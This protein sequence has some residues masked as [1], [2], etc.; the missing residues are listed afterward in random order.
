VWKRLLAVSA[1]DCWSIITREGQGAACFVSGGQYEDAAR[2]PRGHIFI[3]KVIIFLWQAKKSRAADTPQNHVYDQGW[4]FTRK[5]SP[6]RESGAYAASPDYAYDGHT[7]EWQKTC[8][9]K[10]R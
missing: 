8:Q 1:E 10:C 9:N 2:Q 4:G 5:R 7:R 6:L 3:S